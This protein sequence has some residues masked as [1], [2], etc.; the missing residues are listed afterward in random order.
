M[1]G[2]LSCLFAFGLETLGADLG[3][4]SVNFLALQIDGKFP[5]GC[6]VG[7]ATGISGGCSAP[8]GI[9]YSTHSFAVD[10]LQDLAYHG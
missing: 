4:F 9:T 5:F 3:L 2:T 7:M 8:T 6:D 10:L 1:T